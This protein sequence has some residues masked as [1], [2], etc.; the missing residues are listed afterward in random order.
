MF[1]NERLFL[2][3]LNIDMI[4]NEQLNKLQERIS[5]LK[6][7]LDI[8]KKIIEE[9]IVKNLKGGKPRKEYSLINE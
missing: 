2:Y 4:S 6:T 7:Y 3:F 8:D 1:E 5:K 9:T